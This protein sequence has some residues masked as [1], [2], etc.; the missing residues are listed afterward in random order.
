MTVPSW[1]RATKL[2]FFNM[3]ALFQGSPAT[4]DAPQSAHNCCNA[5]KDYAM[6][7]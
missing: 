7:K 6:H 5:I 3:M 1:A 4:R 2:L